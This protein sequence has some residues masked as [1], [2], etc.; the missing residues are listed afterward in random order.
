[1]TDVA[2]PDAATIQDLTIDEAADQIADLPSSLLDFDDGE[3]EPEAVQ[4][5]EAPAPEEAEASEPEEAE[6]TEAEDDPDE[7]EDEAESEEEAP[8]ED[9][10]D[11]VYEVTLPGGEKTEIPVSE[12]VRGYS[13]E[14]DY[15]RKT[16]ALAED[17]RAFEAKQ[18]EALQT[19]EN[20]FRKEA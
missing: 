15:S 10:D 12:L 13:R 19:L 7:G 4:Q 18:F 17:R 6:N 8:Q 1:M 2:T 14:A 11:P 5:E 3:T 20:N 16:A 9:Q